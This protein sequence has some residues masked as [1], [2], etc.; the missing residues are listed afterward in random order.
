MIREKKSLVSVIIPVF[1]AEKYLAEALSSI[2]SQTYSN[3]E[4]IVVDDASTDGSWD[5]VKKF[6]KKYR[7]KL[8]SIKLKKNRGK[9]GEAA[10]DVAYHRAQGYFIAR[11]DADDI[12]HPQ[13]LE[14]QVKFLQKHPDI[15]IVGSSARIINQDGTVVGKKEVLTQHEDIYAQYFTFHP[16][17]HPTLMMRKSVLPFKTKLYHKELPSNNDYLTFFTMIHSGMKFANISES[18]LDY[19]MHGKND[20]LSR[21]KKSFKNTLI[22]RYTMVKA[23]YRP[24]L[25]AWVKCFIQ[26]AVV[27]TLPES[28]TF[29]IYLITRGIFTPQQIFE[30]VKERYFV[31][32][33]GLQLVR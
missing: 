11:M 9:G 4:V 16:M 29:T 10:A 3:F 6:Q 23:G 20:S 1:N 25:T 5:I 2:F 14:K 31:T 27:L 17:I 13:R 28:V 30:S 12:A 15:A 21:V 24:S 32:E 22:T 18:L 33:N 26:A 7:K 19:R 8:V